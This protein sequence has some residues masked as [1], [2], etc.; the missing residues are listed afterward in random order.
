KFIFIPH[1][2]SA[3]SE[4]FD[5][6][7]V[8]LLPAICILF[9]ALIFAN[10]PYYESTYTVEKITKA[11]ATIG[12]GWLAYFM[13]FK[14]SLINLPKTWEKLDH[15]IGVMTLSLTGIFWLVVWLKIS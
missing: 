9:I 7:K 14:N 13:I 5:S 3:A 1:E 15:L 2:Q 6:Q 12:V 10:L 11:L 4:K 8:A